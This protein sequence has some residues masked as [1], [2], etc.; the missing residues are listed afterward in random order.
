MPRKKRT[1]PVELAQRTSD[2]IEVTLFWH[3]GKELSV[4]VSDARTGMAFDIS[5]PADS[6]LDV[7]NH[8]FAHAPVVQPEPLDGVEEPL[9]R[10]QEAA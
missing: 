1:Y 2:G 8:P 9:P 4:H 10:Q 6:A 5:A 3:G 7:F